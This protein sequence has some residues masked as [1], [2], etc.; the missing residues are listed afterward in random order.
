MKKIKIGIDINEVLRA[1]W[2]Q[3]D[4]YFVE[5]FGEDN[6]PD[7]KDLYQYDLFE[8][9]KWEDRVE[10]VKILNEKLPENINPIDYQVDEKTG[11]APVDY[12][13]FKTEKKN[14]TAKESYN[15]F[16][17][18]DY[19]FEIHASAPAMY[20]QMDL[21]F[22]KFILKYGDTVEFVVLSQENWFSIPPT[23][24]YLS[25]IMSRCKNYRFVDNKDEMW[26]DVDIL[27][28]TDPEILD[29]GTPEGKRVIKLLRPYNVDSQ[30]GSIKEEI[31]QIHDL[32]DNLEFQKI[33]N[34]IPKKE[35][36]E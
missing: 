20:N 21:H 19:L 24:F 29:K 16:M 30:D 36:N 27:I 28:T 4:K 3:F 18:E 8:H 26:D 6:L 12:L 2:I 7:T 34:Y 35:E 14:L 11:I 5:E 22:E 15:R 17:Y 32:Q 13:A 9:Y 33:I 10:E 23:L 31:L 1:R 25:K